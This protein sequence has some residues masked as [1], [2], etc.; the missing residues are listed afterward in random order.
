VRASILV[1]WLVAGAWLGWCLFWILRPA[2]DF[3]TDPLG[4]ASGENS[5]LVTGLWNE[6]VAAPLEMHPMA[7]DRY[8]HRLPLRWPDYRGVLGRTGPDSVVPDFEIRT[9]SLRSVGIYLEVEAGLSAPWQE[10]RLL[11]LVGGTLHLPDGRSLV[12]RDAGSARRGQLAEFFLEE[13]SGSMPANTPGIGSLEVF[14]REPRQLFIR[15]M[16]RTIH[17]PAEPASPPLGRLVAAIPGPDSG[18]QESTN[19]FYPDGR[20]T[21]S[22]PVG[23]DPPRRVRLLALAHR[24]SAGF[25]VLGTVLSAAM[26][27]IGSILMQR[28]VSTARHAGIH[29]GAGAGMVLFGLSA[30]AA[31]MVPPLHGPDE[32]RHGLSYARL[33]DDPG[34]FESIK[35]VGHRSHYESL[36]LRSDEKIGEGTFR[37]REDFFLAETTLGPEWIDQF[38]QDYRWRSPTIAKLWQVSGMALNHL[39]AGQV[40]LGL[41]LVDSAVGASLLGFGVGL[42]A[43]AIQKGSGRWVAASPL[44]LF[45]LPAVLAVVSNYSLLTAAAAGSAGCLLRQGWKYET[46]PSVAALTGVCLGLLIHTSINAAPL[47]VG[48]AVWLGHRPIIRWLGHDETAPAVASRRIVGWWAALAAGFGVTRLLSTAAFDRQLTERMAGFPGGNALAPVLSDL[49]VCW[50][51]YCVLVGL[52]EWAVRGARARGLGAGIAACL[53]TARLALGLSAALLLGAAFYFTWATPPTLADRERPWRTYPVIAASGCPLRTLD[54]LEVEAKSL[55]RGAQV[56]KVL[57]VIGGNLSLRPRDFI[58]VRSFWGG[59]LGGEVRIPGWIVPLSSALCVLGLVQGMARVAWDGSSRRIVV[60][61]LAIMA[62]TA[63]VAVLTAGYWPRNLYGRYAFPLFLILLMSGIPGWHPLLKRVG[64]RHSV[65]V[66]AFI[67]GLILTLHGAWVA[68]ISERFF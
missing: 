5:A 7:A 16:V 68:A 26:L 17:G 34:L 42:L 40:L 50:T 32:A 43:G 60:A 8:A 4:F 59:L 57:Q 52:C 28:A 24:T 54:E 1:A 58:L 10:D 67:L 49:G 13:R 3:S 21:Y 38:I 20:C 18:Q 61:W 27:G 66:A 48:A 44:L 65:W 47:V 2:S 51:L 53:Q 22:L 39:P 31:I 64:A 41:R 63:A 46:R 33:F 25:L 36:R 55:S 29:A 15:G 9:N 6:P 56:L 30:T 35:E 23:V 37:E 62:W 45:P 11:G 14:T 12:L 19:L